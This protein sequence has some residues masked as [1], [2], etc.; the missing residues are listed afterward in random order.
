MAP[1]LSVHDDARHTTYSDMWAYGC[2]MLEV[3]PLRDVYIHILTL[4]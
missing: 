2:L 3:Y 4:P 1:E